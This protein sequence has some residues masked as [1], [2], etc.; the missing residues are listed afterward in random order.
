GKAKEEKAKK[1]KPAKADKAAK[2]EKP[3]KEKPAKPASKPAA[4]KKVKF[5]EA[6]YNEAFQNGD[7]NMCAA[8]L[9]G[10][11]DKK[12]EIK[13]FLD[14]DMLLYHE[15]DYQDSGKGFLETYAKMQQATM[16]FNASE[17][18]K[19][20][21]SSGVNRRYKGAE[22]ER[23]LAWSMRLACALSMQ[24]D[25]VAKGIMN[26]YVGTFMQEIQELRAKNAQFEAE[27]EAALES[28]E[29][30]EAK[31]KLSSSGVNLSFVEAPKKSDEKYESSPFFNYLGTVAYATYGDIDHA[32][33]FGAVYKVP[34]VD[35]ITK[36]PA[37]KGRLEVVAL[38]GM[39]G[40]RED[41][42]E[43]KEPQATILPIPV[44][45]RT[46]PLY[47]KI[48]YPVFDKNAQKHNIK[49]VR[50][51]LSNGASSNATLIEDFD[52]AVRIDVAQKAYGDY[53]RSV[54]RNVVKN[55]VVTASVI[56]AGI[57]LNQASQK[58]P[59]AAAIAQ[60][61][62]DAAVDAAANAVADKERADIRQG[63]Y[64]PNKAS[65]AGFSVAPGTY[66]VT[67]EYLDASGK[68]VETKTIE[69]VEVQA[70]KV[71]V[72]VSSCEK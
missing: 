71:S 37:G 57:A 5:D 70:G 55:S 31:E 45:N 18:G 69:N 24:R 49:S 64:F 35:E 25:D 61:A 29:Y 12:N 1:E 9:L 41:V 32:E 46:I 62:F 21:K 43:G 42:S 47:T 34:R 67:V 54:F 27:A 23:Y 53:N 22:Y 38:S 48:A 40:K 17:E 30:K 19:A 59:L 10:K 20:A 7:Y 2:D 36:I 16:S 6:K 8:M 60:V 13:D 39:I 28:D 26:D 3:A 4:P 15:A 14:V 56:A 65:R 68:A 51:L 66:N 50:V 33:E 44:L 63:S 52:D 11:G 72:R 58:S